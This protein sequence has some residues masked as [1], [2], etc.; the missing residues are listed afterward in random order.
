MSNVLKGLRHK[1][2]LMLRAGGPDAPRRSAPSSPMR[3]IP[4]HKHGFAHRGSSPVQAG[5]DRPDGHRRRQPGR[6]EREL[7]RPPGGGGAIPAHLDPGRGEF[8]ELDRLRMERVP[9]GDQPHGNG[10]GRGR[11]LQGQGPGQVRGRRQV[12]VG[13]G[14]DRHGGRSTARGRTKP[15]TAGQPHRD[16]AERV[17]HQHLMGPGHHKLGRAHWQQRNPL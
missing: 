3:G 14:R 16:P 7:D 9:A 5:R 11:S 6:A 10:P 2:A 12:L 8:Q 1:K 4:R 13:N 17:R 15:P